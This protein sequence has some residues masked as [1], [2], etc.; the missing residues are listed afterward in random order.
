MMCPPP[1]HPGRAYLQ[2]RVAIKHEGLHKDGAVKAVQI[3]KEA[4]QLNKHCQV[5]AAVGRQLG[6]QALDE[7]MDRVLAGLLPPAG[8][9]G[10]GVG[11]AVRR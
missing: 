5:C 10:Q 9:R 7:V 8:R 1:P 2:L 3:G 4:V 11:P 6:G